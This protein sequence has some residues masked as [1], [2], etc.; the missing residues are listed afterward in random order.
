MLKITP[1][2]Y[3]PAGLFYKPTIRDPCTF[4]CMLQAPLGT[5][6][7]LCSEIADDVAGSAVKTAYCEDC[8]PCG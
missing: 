6:I 8:L 2:I 5:G 7:V 4:F 1:T 3:P